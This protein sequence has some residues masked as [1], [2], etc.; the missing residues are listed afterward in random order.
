MVNV[1]FSFYQDFIYLFSNYHYF[2]Y[3]NTYGMHHNEMNCQMNCIR[4]NELIFFLNGKNR[5]GCVYCPIAYIYI[6][7]IFQKLSFVISCE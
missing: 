2:D 6:F 5:I 4:H 7:C 1:K 3:L